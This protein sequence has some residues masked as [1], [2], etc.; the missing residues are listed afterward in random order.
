MHFRA[1][2]VRAIRVERRSHVTLAGDKRPL[3][4]RAAGSLL[5][6]RAALVLSLAPAASAQIV[7]DGGSG[8]RIN[9]LWDNAANW[10]GDTIPASG[11]D[12]SFAT[13]FAP[14]P[15]NAT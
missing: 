4:C 12:V 5:T 15:G 10:V 3:R 8:V 14:G 7:W 9:A 11:D 6:A 13:G 2:S 1:R